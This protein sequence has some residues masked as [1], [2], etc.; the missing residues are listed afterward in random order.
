MRL[1]VDGEAVEHWEQLISTLPIG[2]GVWSRC[3][4]HL[5]PTTDLG[6]GSQHTKKNETGEGVR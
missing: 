1:K 4:S 3:Y 2:R 5:D 6:T